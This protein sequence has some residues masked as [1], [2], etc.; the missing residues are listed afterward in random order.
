[1]KNYNFSIIIPHKNIT[2]LLQRCL[3][4]IPSREDIQI[5]VVDDNSNPEK[6]DFNRFPGAGRANVEVY[7][8]KSGKGAGRARNI[9]LAHALGEWVLFSDADDCFETG[10]SEIL[11]YLFNEDS[12]DI[13][14]FDVI[15][16]DSD[17]L[18][19]TEE[20][21]A[22]SKT[23]HR[24]DDFELRYGLLTPWMKAVRR[25]FIVNHGIKFEEVPCGNDTRFSALCGYYAKK[26]NVLDIVGY[27]W[28]RRNNSLW[29]NIDINWCITRYK[30]S[31]SLS[32]F[33]RHHK[34]GRAQKHFEYSSFGFLSRVETFSKYKYVWYLLQ[35]G[36]ETRNRGIVFRHVPRYCFLHLKLKCGINISIKDYIR[37]KFGLN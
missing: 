8:D 18:D 32:R 25:S 24:R 21:N 13:V 2:D 15:S 19:K 20:S 31:M 10:I 34:E 22:F 28:M 9:G 11:E 16:K 23:L 6:V 36:I 5:I 14:Y 12:A 17:T 7:F 1:M 3:D 37:S 26:I 27:C 4:S 30:V 33:M 35:Y 29:R